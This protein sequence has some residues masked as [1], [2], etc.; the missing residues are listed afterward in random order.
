LAAL[1]S[2]F[3]DLRISALVR[4]PSDHAAVQALSPS[5]R[6]IAADKTDHALIQSTSA[7]ADV[8][9]SAL[10]NN[11]VELTRA[12]IAGLEQRAANSSSKK[13][14][15]ISTGGTGV[16][17]EGSDGNFREG[18]TVDD[19]QTHDIKSIPTERPHRP[20]DLE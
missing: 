8:V 10:D 12:I 17:G 5:I 2:E 11:D 14:V 18:S 1:V 19:S 3:K 20:V 6:V 7:S 16:L 13:P 9:I 4:K 15:L